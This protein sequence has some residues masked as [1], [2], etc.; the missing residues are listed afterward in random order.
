MII[1]MGF[2]QSSLPNTQENRTLNGFSSDLNVR[3]KKRKISKKKKKDSGQRFP[4]PCVI[5]MLVD[6]KYTHKSECLQV[7][8]DFIG[9]P[10]ALNANITVTLYESE[11]M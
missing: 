3:T 9:I 11:G 8:V 6:V 1:T 5:K 10:W 4:R 2:S 7:S